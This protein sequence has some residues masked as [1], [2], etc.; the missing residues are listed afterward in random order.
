MQRRKQGPAW[1]RVWITFPF[2]VFLHLE[3]LP[4]IPW[5]LFRV[6]LFLK[7]LENPTDLSL[8]GRC[9]YIAKFSSP[10]T[11]DLVFLSALGSSSFQETVQHS[12]R[13]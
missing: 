3:G 8:A 5:W 9:I 12:P 13:V 7:R 6:H 11:A 2:L 1:K 4:S 10:P